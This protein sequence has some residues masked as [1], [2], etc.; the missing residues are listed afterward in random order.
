MVGVPLVSLYASR[1]RLLDD[2]KS[3]ILILREA[4]TNLPA[5]GLCLNHLCVPAV[6]ASRPACPPPRKLPSATARNGDPPAQADDGFARSERA[7]RARA[8]RFLQCRY[9]DA[10]R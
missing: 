5:C 3:V 7:C 2:H 1:K 9:D 4:E 8:V 10:A 6:T